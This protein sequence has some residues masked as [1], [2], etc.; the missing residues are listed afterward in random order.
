MARSHYWSIVTL[1]LSRNTPVQNDD[2]QTTV[3]ALPMMAHAL[4]SSNM[5]KSSLWVIVDVASAMWHTVVDCQH[6]LSVSHFTRISEQLSE[7]HALHVDCNRLDRIL[8]HDVH[9]LHEHTELLRLPVLV[10]RYT[11]LHSFLFNVLITFPLLR[12]CI[13]CQ[14]FIYVEMLI[15]TAILPTYMIRIVCLVNQ[16]ALLRTRA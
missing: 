2:R 12:T 10:P 7:Q 9:I 16:P 15:D 5:E 14:L 6:Q 3:I 1:G 13:R 4:A 11:N 8:H